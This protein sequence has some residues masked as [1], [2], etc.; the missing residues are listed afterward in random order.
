MNPPAPL[1]HSM[2]SDDLT[3]KNAVVFWTG[4]KDG[5]YSCYKAMNDGYN[6]TTYL[7]HFTNLKKTDLA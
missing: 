3:L 2:H 6:I 7:L 1:N 4:G 5:C